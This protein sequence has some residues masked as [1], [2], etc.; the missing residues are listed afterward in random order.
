MKIFLFFF[1]V[2]ISCFSQT[3]SNDQIS[4]SYKV[5]P[6]TI[7]IKNIE[8]DLKSKNNN[9]TNLKIV[10]QMTEAYVDVERLVT[11]KLLLNKE[12]SIFYRE[13]LM[14]PEDIKGTK[15]IFIDNFHDY[16]FYTNQNN[17]ECYRVT[18]LRGVNYLVSQ[19]KIE[20][21]ITD[22]E[23]V[24]NG[25]M[26]LKAYGFNKM[27]NKSFS[28]WFSPQIP[29]NIGPDMCYDLPGL[30]LEYNLTTYSIVC[31]KIDFY[32]TEEN[33]KKIKKPKGELISQE[34]F[35]EIIKKARN[36]F[37]N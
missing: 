22:E 24:I 21:E 29:F 20:W 25:F 32:L 8:K 6:N 10:N 1:F 37:K 28:V 7:E 19:E 17:Q 14:L 9:E 5:I 26:C 3:N 12:E 36:S 11:F 16:F 34:D 23:K 33:I 27:Q 15:K 4:V 31:D 18:S 35:N 30:V 13:E 2:N